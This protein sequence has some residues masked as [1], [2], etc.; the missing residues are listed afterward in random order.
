MRRWTIDEVRA[1]GVHTDLVTACSARYGI[2][3]NLSW[4]KYHAGELD[5]PTA[6]VGRRVVVPVRPLL[7]LLGYETSE[8]GPIPGPAAATF[9]DPEN[10]HANGASGARIIR[11][12]RRVG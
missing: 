4:E 10:P 1:L 8:A 2:G 5:F 6:R 9:T 3:K 11:P 12:L 7:E